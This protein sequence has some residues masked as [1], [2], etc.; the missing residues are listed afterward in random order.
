MMQSPPKKGAR[1]QKHS[2]MKNRLTPID[3]T[4]L[5]ASEQIPSNQGQMP[6]YRQ[7]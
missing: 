5:V 7:E 4:M 2:M 3:E 1:N 6:N